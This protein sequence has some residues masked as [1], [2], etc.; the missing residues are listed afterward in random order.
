M[1]FNHCSA[2]EEK[3]Q[4]RRDRGREIFRTCT[5][6]DAQSLVSMTRPS[7]L[8]VCGLISVELQG[9]IFGSLVDHNKFKTDLALVTP[10]C[11]VD[12]RLYDRVC[13][14]WDGMSVGSGVSSTSCRGW[15]FGPCWSLS[16]VVSLDKR[17]HPPCL[18]CL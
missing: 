7:C 12:I 3:A 18:Q 2:L 11:I 14:V 9:R 4:R 16:A 17:L 1:I 8:S 13:I 5:K 6:N 15:W 10:V